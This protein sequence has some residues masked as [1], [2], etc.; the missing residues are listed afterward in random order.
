MDGLVD[1]VLGHHPIGRVLTACDHHQARDTV[2]DSMF[3]G[4]CRRVGA[5]AGQQRAQAGVDPL[6]VVLGE[7]NSQHGVDLIQQVADVLL[8][9]RGGVRLVE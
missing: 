7:R 9:R 8:A 3:T 6:D 4:Q 5:F 1:G 2:C